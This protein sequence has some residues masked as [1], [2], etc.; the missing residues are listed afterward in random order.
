M[1]SNYYETYLPI[2]FGSHLGLSGNTEEVQYSH[3]LHL[4]NFIIYD[5]I[6]QR[7]R[8]SEIR[9]FIVESVS[10]QFMFIF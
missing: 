9:F 8:I 7:R 3:T 1:V 4:N 6:R 2:I 5:T 10:S